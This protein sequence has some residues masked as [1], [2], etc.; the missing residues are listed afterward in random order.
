MKSDNEN[1]KKIFDEAIAHSLREDF[2]RY[3]DTTVLSDKEMLENGYTLP[4]EDMPK[5]I[6]QLCMKRKTAG[7]RSY[8]IK[9]I[10]LIAA[11]VAALV[12]GAMSVTAV[13]K[14]V[15]EIM[16][17]V[18]GDSVEFMIGANIKRKYSGE[19]LYAYNRIEEGTGKKPLKPAYLPDGMTYSESNIVSENKV[20]FKYGDGKRVVR[21]SVEYVSGDSSSGR[22]LST[23]AAKVFTETVNGYEVSVTEYIRDEAGTFM[24]DVMW[25]ADDFVYS[26]TGDVGTDEMMK[27]VRGME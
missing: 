4:P 16:G 3:D 26:I 13:R 7:K 21:L 10:V 23:S 20:L 27:I 8:N 12:C 14:Y 18:T 24:T 22:S 17:S 1:I 11:I 2:N 19:E 6:K 25:S 9:R 15:I 5:R